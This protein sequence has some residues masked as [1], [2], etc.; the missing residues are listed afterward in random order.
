MYGTFK[1]NRRK[2]QEEMAWPLE[3]TSGG[4]SETGWRE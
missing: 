2:K 3:I 1:K 4:H